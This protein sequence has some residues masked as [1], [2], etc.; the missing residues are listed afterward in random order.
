M[1]KHTML[2]VVSFLVTAFFGGCQD[3]GNPS[4]NGRVPA[5]SYRYEGYDSK[6]NS[7][8]VG[9]MSFS[10]VD[11]VSIRGEWA[12]EKNGP[13]DNIGPQI[14]AGQLTG[15]VDDQVV[16][17]NLNPGWVDNNVVLQGSFENE[18]LRG[19]WSWITFAGPTT[20]GTFDATKIN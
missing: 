14:G 9:T 10:F 3:R 8:V 7:I 12:L 20:E 6:G 13:S 2:L 18:R 15:R 5:G 17:I 16:S 4:G 1:S 19:K 11:S